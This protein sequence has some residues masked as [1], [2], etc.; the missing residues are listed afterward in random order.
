MTKKSRGK[1]SEN[2]S[3][4]KPSH[5]IVPEVVEFSELS[6]DEASER[7]RLE[8]QVERAFYQAGAALA[9]IRIQRLYRS[10]HATFEDYCQDRFSFTRRH[11]NYLISAAQVVDNLKMGTICSQSEEEL[12]EQT[13]LILPTTAS[14]CRPLSPL[15]PE[16]QVEAWT[17]AVE[18]AG[19][20]VP[21]SR[22]VK[23]VVQQILQGHRVPNPWRVGEV[24]TIMVKENPDLRGKG[25]CWAIITEVHQFSCTVRLWDGEY[26]VKSQNLKELPYS[27]AQQDEVKSLCDRL[28]QIRVDDTEKPVRDFLAGLGKLDRPWLTELEERMLRFL[29]ESKTDGSSVITPNHIN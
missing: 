4:S 28:S 29:E 16:Q 17:Q 25:G 10:T 24:A 2:D 23:D 18:Q 14:Q 5:A 8:R 19:R 12:E 22:I 11:V 26:Q 13:G 9:Q 1:A 3:T 7:L 27:R 20:K 6:D 21:T 15:D